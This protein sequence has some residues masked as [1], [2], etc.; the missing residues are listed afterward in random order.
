MIE[1]QRMRNVLHFIYNSLILSKR[2]Q[3]QLLERLLEE[4][5]KTLW[6]IYY[7]FIIRNKTLQKEAKAIIPYKCLLLSVCNTWASMALRQ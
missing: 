4:T 7:A 5:I 3:I 6:L 2:V 1:N